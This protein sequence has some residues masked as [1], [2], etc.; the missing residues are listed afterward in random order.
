MEVNGGESALKDKTQFF[1]F[2]YSLFT[3]I[4]NLTNKLQNTE[5][6]RDLLNYIYPGTDTN[7]MEE[8]ISLTRLGIA[9]AFMTAASVMDWRTR[10]VAN[11][12]WIVLGIIGMGLLAFEMLF[13][14]AGGREFG[15][16]HFL[17]FIPLAIIFFDV[18]WDREPIYWEGKVNPAPILLLAIAAIISLAMVVGEGLT[19][20]TGALLAIPAVM[21]TFEAFYY[22]GVI[23]GGADAKAM[24]ALALMFPFYPLISGLPFLAYPERAVDFIQMTFPFS[25]LILMNAAIIHAVSGP[26]IRFFRNLVRK[27]FGFPEMF[28][29]YRMD[30]KDVPKKFVWP[31][32]AVR[33]DEVVLVLFPK[34]SDDVKVELAKLKA[35]GL[36]RI[37][38]TPKDPFIIPMTLGIIFSAVVGNLIILLFPF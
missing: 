38:V 3:K 24:M 13:A 34:R 5:L 18:F 6:L 17:I 20:E 22:L 15:L 37:W 7:A 33:E 23:R 30:L 29:G 35:K 11:R 36:E 8:I 26:L 9:L 10:K 1:I 14:E 28:L 31:M 32:E 2:H 16:T 4:Y 25:F 27:D 12:V 21:L 19:M